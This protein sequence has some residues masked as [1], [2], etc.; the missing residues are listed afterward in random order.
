MIRSF[1]TILFSMALSF[2]AFSAQVSVDAALSSSTVV[3]EV[4]GTKVTLG[5]LEQKRAD[6]LFQAQDAY[7]KTERNALVDLANEMVLNKEAQKEGVT[8]DKLLDEHVKSKLPKDPGDEALRVFYEGLDTRETYDAL[9]GRIL[10]HIHQTRYEK[11]RAAY[12]QALVAKANIQIMLPPPRAEVSLD[13]TPVLGRLDAPVKFVEFADYECPYC[14]QVAPALDRLQSEYKDKVVFAFKDTPLPMH[15]H[16]EK[17]AEAAHCAGVQ[18][19][20]WEYHTALFSNKKLEIPD[21]KQDARTLKLDGAAFDK[22]LDSGAEADVV[23][24]QLEQSQK[25]G[26]GGTPIFFING[27]M[28]SGAQNYEQLRAAIE[29]ELAIARREPKETTTTASR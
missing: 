9:K 29:Q 24:A 17:A 13:N 6:N 28:L 5:E 14:Q 2:T 23:K 22:C 4:D 12:V 1:L 11:A 27:R 21:L 20:Y 7:Y 19:K 18:G 3:A 10:E 26:L 25:L 8:I 15:A 16:A